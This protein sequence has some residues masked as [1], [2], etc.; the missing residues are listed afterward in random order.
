MHEMRE[1]EYDVLKGKK[2]GGNMSEQNNEGQGN[3]SNEE[4]SST[5][6]DRNVAGLLCYFLGLLTGVLFFLLEKDSKFVKFHA[7]QSIFISL[8]LF[9]LNLVLSFVPVVGWMLNLLL[10]PVSIVL[11]IVL[12]VKA[13]KGEVFKLPVLG[14]MAEKQLES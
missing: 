2:G 6:L 7:L 1:G 8:F 5:G 10:W 12:M 3:H 4:K 11:W 13:Y 14:G 9:V